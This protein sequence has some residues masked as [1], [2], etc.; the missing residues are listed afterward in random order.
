ME[1]D[2]PTYSGKILERFFTEKLVNLQR[3]SAIGIWWEKG[4]QNELDIVAVDDFTKVVLFAEV[5]R[6]KENISISV[7]QD[8]AQKLLQ[9]QLKDY[10]AEYRGFSM[11]DM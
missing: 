1:R 3:Y 4:N 7:L 5:K 6:K 10:T 9:S 11:E 8:K 2:Y